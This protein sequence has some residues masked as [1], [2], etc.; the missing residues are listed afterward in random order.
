MTADAPRQ[1]PNLAPP[2]CT[3]EKAKKANDPA[4]AAPTQKGQIGSPNA[5]IDCRTSG[6]NLR[7]AYRLTASAGGG[8]VEG[9][10]RGRR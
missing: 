1:E 8:E 4:R 5:A 9:K 10:A 6:P 2:P 3:A 7:K